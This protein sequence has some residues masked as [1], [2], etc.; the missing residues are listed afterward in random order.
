MSVGHPRQ[1]PKGG[2]QAK[3]SLPSQWSDWKKQCEWL[4]GISRAG[5]E[6]CQGFVHPLAVGG[7]A[8]RPCGGAV[9]APGRPQHGAYAGPAEIPCPRAFPL[10]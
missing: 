8:R 4:P 7:R 3:A 9:Q 1:G 2:D 10:Q 6:T 5:S